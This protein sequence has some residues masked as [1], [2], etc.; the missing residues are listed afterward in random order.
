MYPTIDFDSVT[1]HHGIPWVMKLSSPVAITLPS[2]FG[3]HQIHIYFRDELDVCSCEGM[4]VP[5]HESFHVLQYRDLLGGW[6]L[7]YLRSFIVAYIGC[8]ITG[9][10][11]EENVIETPAYAQ[12]DRFRTC[13]NQ[14]RER[15]CDCAS[16]APV[17][18]QAA[19]DAMFAGCPDLVR[20]SS[21]LGLWEATKACSPAS[22]WLAPF[23]FL[24]SLILT[25]L[26]AIL[27][28]IAE[29]ILL[30]VDG[31]LWVAT[32]IVCAAE[33]I[34][35]WFTA[36]WKWFKGKLAKACDWAKNLEEKCALWEKTK[37]KECKE[38]KDLGYEECAQ[39]ED[40]GYEACEQEE[41]QG[42]MECTEKAD[43][44]YE[45]CAVE[46]DHG[47]STCAQEQDQG[48]N[49]C[50]GWIPCKWACKAW[51]W[52]S[53]IVCVLY[54]WV[55]NIVCVLKTWVENIVCVAETWIEHLVCV[56]K[57]W[58]ENIVCV[59][60]TWIENIVCVAWTWIV[61]KTCKAF[62]WVVKGAICWAK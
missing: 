21:G 40:Q 8:G 49:K 20:T 46:E 34:W 52:V 60:K 56:V 9:G 54:T 1:F 26:A 18:N 36:I 61:S 24:I 38:K 7:G 44:G 16:G 12:E 43:L 42:Y 28:P 51:V 22:R 57:T 29:L 55:Q 30:F 41:D 33:K 53:H 32:G 6:G 31:L 62:T 45:A 59:L 15:V 37:K 47:Y 3:V 19:L 50:C 5:V 35:K 10:G 4:V 17:F 11:G 13:C 39:E 25:V 2:T 48:Y 27:K 14:R 23:W 58:V